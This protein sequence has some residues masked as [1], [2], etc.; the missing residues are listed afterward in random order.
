MNDK[1]GK[2]Y[3]GVSIAVSLVLHFLILQGFGWAEKNKNA[4]LNDSFKTKVKKHKAFESLSELDLIE[5]NKKLSEIIPQEPVEDLDLAD[6]SIQGELE[7]LDEDLRLD[8]GELEQEELE[9]SLQPNF[10]SQDLD[11][12]LI[13][14]F[15]EGPKVNE[16]LDFKVPSVGAV[17]SENLALNEQSLSKLT[18]DGT[19]DL[20]LPGLDSNEV[21]GDLGLSFQ[22]SDLSPLEGEIE[23]FI[24]LED[25]EQLLVFDNFIEVS[26]QVYKDYENLRGYYE[27]ALTPTQDSER[28]PEVPK[29]IIFVIDTSASISRYKLQKFKKAIASSLSLLKQ[30]DRFNIVSFKTEAKSCFDNFSSPTENKIEEAKD[31]LKS[32]RSSGKTDVYASV[33]PYLD[34]VKAEQDRPVLLFLISDGQST[35]NKKASSEV[36]KLLTEDNKNKVSI[37]AFS[38]GDKIDTFLLDFLTFR[39]RGYSLPTHNERIADAKLLD[40]LTK[41]SR[42]IIS[43]LKHTV[44]KELLTEIYPR[45]LPHMYK[46]QTLK[47]Y[48]S[49]PLEKKEMIFRILGKSGR[50]NED[51]LFK[52]DFSKNLTEDKQVARNWAA[53]KMLDLLGYLD[54]SNRA[55]VLA[56][57]HQLTQKFDIVLPYRF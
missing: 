32:L 20:D 38:C 40:Y 50:G 7:N 12:S 57:I 43:D 28:L 35:V 41:T 16:E 21:I 37:S 42:V 27:I 49:F 53:K 46:G 3:I 6:E 44:N 51:I 23:S 13:G 29:D 45:S 47:V 55:K 26:T 56:E 14:A 11:E 4:I 36:I 2:I 33:K 25:E 5:L 9:S 52:V 17:D 34:S 31:F 10:V 1:Q 39:N 18:S 54:E 22:D 19:G 24:E 15:A 30:D 48:G 8:L